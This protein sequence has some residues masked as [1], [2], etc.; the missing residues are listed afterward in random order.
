MQV[1]SLRTPYGRVDVCEEGR[2]VRGVV[3]T[4]D[5][6]HPGETPETPLS[7]DL[8]RYLDG[9]PVDFTGHE[10]DLSGYTPFEVQVLLATRR[11]PY[12]TV[13]T[14]RE[15]AEEVGRPRA[16]RAVAYT[17]TKNRACIVIP[18]HRVIE[19]GGRLG[20]YSAGPEWKRN[21]LRLEGAIG[22]ERQPP[23]KGR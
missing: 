20:G 11:I 1:T 3:L 19:S 13:R 14:Y 6:E 9:E 18:C 22:E 2:R 21:L 5:R 23:S 17:L 8:Q 12:G 7:Q 15:I 4:D 10:V 16:H